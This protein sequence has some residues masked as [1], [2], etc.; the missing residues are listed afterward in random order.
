MHVPPL[1]VIVC[2]YN[3]AEILGQTL[4]SF[5][6]LNVPPGA[7]YELLLVDNNSSDQTKAVCQRFEGRLPLRY[8]FEP[9]QGKTS[10]LNRALQE[11][12]GKL[13]LFTDD[14]VQLAPQWVAAF[15][16]AAV[17]HPEAGW[18][19]GRIIPWWEEGRPR[20]LK[21]ECLPALSGFFGLYDLGDRVRAYVPNDCL[22]AGAGMAVRRSTFDRVGGYRE[23]LGPRGEKK[24]T[25]DDTELI[26]RALKHGIEGV[27]VPEATCR[28][29]VPASRLSMPWFVKYGMGKGENQ[30]RAMGALCP[31]GSLWRVAN[32]TV[33][34]VPQW[35]RGRGD[36]VRICCLN[37]GIELGRR[38][39]QR[40]HARKPS[41]VLSTGGK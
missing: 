12:Q 5:L 10:A 27:Y 34:G 8:L 40:A 17:D 35:L 23:D 3:R 15:H 16:A 18:F 1:S 14:D 9:K 13:L 4:E 26:E 37:V 19:G 38:R 7:S 2:T 22:P 28:H 20:W 6:G 32:Q 36:R 33:R 30:A 24:G 25:H 41:P 11:A 31:S 29:F 39:V 21:D